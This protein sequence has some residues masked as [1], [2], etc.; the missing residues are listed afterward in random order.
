[1]CGHQ[2]EYAIP[3]NKGKN[4]AGVTPD[5]LGKVYDNQGEPNQIWTYPNS[6]L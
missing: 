1:M 3:E 6:V 2:S 4:V 5:E